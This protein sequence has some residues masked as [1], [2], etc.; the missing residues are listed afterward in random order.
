MSI[1]FT[2]TKVAGEMER[3]WMQKLVL[4]QEMLLKITLNF[5]PI[6]VHTSIS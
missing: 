5:I 2:L 1:P 3:A 6:Y 4:N